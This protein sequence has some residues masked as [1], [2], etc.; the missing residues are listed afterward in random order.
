MLL[1]HLVDIRNLQNEVVRRCKQRGLS[2]RFEPD[3]PTAYTNRDEMVFPALR[4]P[5]SRDQ[6]LLLACQAAHE[7]GHQIRSESLR[8][9]EEA[10]IKMGS[11]LAQIWNIVEDECMERE[12]QRT[13]RG[14]RQALVE[15]HRILAEQSSASWSEHKHKQPTEESKKAVAAYLC[16]IESRKDWD[17]HAAANA[18]LIRRAVPSDVITLADELISE[19]WHHQINA[20]GDPVTSKLLAYS[21]YERLYPGQKAE[22]EQ[23]PEPQEGEGEGEGEGEQKQKGEAGDEEGEDQAPASGEGEPTDE[24]GEGESADTHFIVKWSDVVTSNHKD[25]KGMTQG[26]SEI[27]WTG[28]NNEGVIAYVSEES[29]QVYDYTNNKDCAWKGRHGGSALADKQFA[30]QV[31]RL[32]QATQRTKRVS[33]LKSGK[34]DKRNMV[35]VLLPQR[36]G[37]EWNKR[38]F[39]DKQDCRTLNTAITLLVD[40]SGSMQ[41]TKMKLA[42]HSTQRLLDTFDRALH[43]PCEIISFTGGWNDMDLGIIKSFNERSVTSEDVDRRLTTFEAYTSGN[44]DGDAIMWAAERLN[45]RREMRKVMIVLSDGSPAG[46]SGDSGTVLTASIAEVRRM[47]IEIHGIGIE[48]NAVQHFYGAD[49]Q[50]INKAEQLNNALLRTLEKVIVK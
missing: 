36:E 39:Y 1:A 3:L 8:L 30:N 12:V 40:W 48:S 19:G 13:F 15:G 44:P 11:P 28:H 2:V 25:E 35:R 20:G 32:I 50:V 45:A 33:E 22:D 46:G 47:G 26:S 18:D 6:L 24:E 42:C 4:P 29:I 5:I 23:Q 16:A 27:D 38:V 37:G 43:V 17:Y 31:R 14:D 49:C 21:L 34:L 9:L 41:G 7:P 10:R